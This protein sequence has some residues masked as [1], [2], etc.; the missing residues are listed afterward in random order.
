MAKSSGTSEVIKV[1]LWAVA[2][3]IAYVIYRAWANAPAASST[4]SS[5]SQT[6]VGAG[7]PT[8]TLVGT[9]GPVVAS[10]VPPALSSFSNV[11]QTLQ[12]ILQSKGAPIANPV[13]PAWP[14]W[15]SNPVRILS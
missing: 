5:G 2:I 6:S 11:E 3:Y 4:S 7:G 9:T 8:N 1:G 15:G 14:I 10:S 12:K 13:G